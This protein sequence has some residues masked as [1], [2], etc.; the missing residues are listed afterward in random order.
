MVLVNV[1]H[2][3]TSSFCFAKLRIRTFLMIFWI[4][5]FT[6]SR[7]FNR[8]GVGK[9]QSRERVLVNASHL[10]T[11]SFCFAKLRI[12]TLYKMC[13]NR[14]SQF[15][16]VRTFGLSLFTKSRSEREKVKAE[17]GIRT[18]IHRYLQTIFGLVRTFGLS[19]FTRTPMREHL[20]SS[21]KGYC[22]RLHS[23]SAISAYVHM[24]FKY[25]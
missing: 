12:R 11:S 22:S 16:L 1:S 6:M 8:R 2:L 13:K 25:Y 18:P 10:R 14:F 7:R 17:K 19:L 24:Y 21:G 3:R 9:G 23:H 5:P 4:E 20:V 15:G